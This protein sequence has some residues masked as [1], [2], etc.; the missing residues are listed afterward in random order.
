MEGSKSIRV[1]H[2]WAPPSIA[3]Q[4]HYGDCNGLRKGLIPLA[5]PLSGVSSCKEAMGNRNEG[6]RAAS[7][8]LFHSSGLI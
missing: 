1:Q 3:S 7:L 8:P 5:L 6:L 2:T 4:A